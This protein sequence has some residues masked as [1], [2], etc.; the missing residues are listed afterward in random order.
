MQELMPNRKDKPVSHTEARKRFGYLAI[1]KGFVTEDQFIE[2]MRIQVSDEQTKNGYSPP[3]GE[4][5]KKMGL[6]REEEVQEVVREGLG[7]ERYK[8]PICGMLLHECPNCGADLMQF[9]M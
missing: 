5:M 2:A 1:K 4:I 8:C 9:G 6:M 3:I 7:F